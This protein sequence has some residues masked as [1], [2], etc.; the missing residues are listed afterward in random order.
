LGGEQPPG[1][2]FPAAIRN[3]GL[4]RCV[5]RSHKSDGFERGQMA[6]E[7]K[8][9]LK[10]R[11]PVIV[12]I[13]RQRKPVDELLQLGSGSILEF[14]KSAD[15][16]LELLVNN[17]PIGRGRAVKVGENFGLRLTQIGNRRERVQALAGESSPESGQS[18]AEQ[19]APSAEALA[20]QREGHE[21]G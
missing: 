1:P 9:I 18:E 11:V 5:A 3:A 17:K 6:T 19:P 15:D 7:L 4:P 21:Q 2:L 20:S 16:D 10:L 14:E 13:C 12:Q 8:T